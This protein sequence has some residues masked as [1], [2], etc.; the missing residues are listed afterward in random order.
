[1][2]DLEDIAQT[3]NNNND[4]DEYGDMPGLRSQEDN[5][6]D[7]DDE[8]EEDYTYTNNK[9]I[10]GVTIRS[11]CVVKQAESYKDS[12]YSYNQIGFC[13]FA[14]SESRKGEKVQV[15]SHE[16]EVA[17]YIELLTAIEDRISK[18]VL[19]TSTISELSN[20]LNTVLKRV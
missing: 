2:P 19:T 1:M 15:L 20:S 10:P 12:D 11:G 13:Y 7:D 16:D 18:R 4:D 9:G 6:N 8:D 5:D 14:F 3:F 17:N